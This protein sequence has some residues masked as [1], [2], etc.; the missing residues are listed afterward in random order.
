MFFTS[1]SNLY[2]IFRRPLPVLTFILSLNN[3]ILSYY[4]MLCVNFKDILNE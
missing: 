2:H 1:L 3:N 4:K